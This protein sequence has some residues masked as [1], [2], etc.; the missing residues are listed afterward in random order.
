M[1]T[2]S[3]KRCQIKTVSSIKLKIQKLNHEKT[4]T[5]KT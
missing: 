3:R 1:Q 5:Q 2:D 4:E